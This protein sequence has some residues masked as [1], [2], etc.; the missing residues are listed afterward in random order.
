M[1]TTNFK[2]VE[3]YIAAQPQAAQGVLR[4]VRSAVRRALGRAEET[5]SY[6]IPTYKL[7]GTFVLSFAAWKRHWSIYPVS[8]RLA[9]A[10]GN[11]L[12]GGRVEKHTLRFPL[13]APVPVKLIGQFASFR[14]AE[15]AERGKLSAT[16]S[17]A[18]AEQTIAKS[19]KNS[20]RRPSVRRL[21]DEGSR[22]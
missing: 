21:I 16:R 20:L 6:N 11:Q 12:A 8:A 14:V 19:R 15:Q 4:K 7:N 1:T 9:E 17:A 2:S 18:G 22:G 13:D 10:F 3:D 5:I